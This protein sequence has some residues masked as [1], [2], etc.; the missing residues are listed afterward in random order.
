MSNDQPVI[1]PTVLGQRPPL[2]GE[3]LTLKD[4]AEILIRHYKLTEG[5]YEPSIEINFTVANAGPSPDK[6]LP[7]AIVSFSRIGLAISSEISPLAVDAS[8][9]VQAED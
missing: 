1:P 4:L 9:V 6:V 2:V 3:Q 8:K 5:F 7:S